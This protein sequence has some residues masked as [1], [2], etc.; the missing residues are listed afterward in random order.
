MEA[1]RRKTNKKYQLNL[2]GIFIQILANKTEKNSK[3]IKK[4]Y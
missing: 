1:K 3:K 2:T 4:L